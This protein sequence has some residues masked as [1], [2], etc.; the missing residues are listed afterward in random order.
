[1]ELAD[2]RLVVDVHLMGAAICCKAVWETM[3]EQKSGRIVMTTSSSGLY[4]NFGQANYGAAK[5]SL[6]G[7]MQTLAIEG[8]KYGI[9]VNCLAPTAYTR[10]M[11]GILPQE[12]LDVLD[13]SLV[14]PA[15]LPLVS[16][17]GCVSSPVSVDPLVSVPPVSASLAPLS[18][19]CESVP[20][21][22]PLEMAAYARALGVTAA[23]T[24]NRGEVGALPQDFADM[25]GWKE[26]AEAVAISRRLAEVG[27]A[28]TDSAVA[29][30]KGLPDVAD[31]DA[32]PLGHRLTVG[33]KSG[34]R[35]GIVPLAD[36]KKPAE[37]P[38]LGA[39]ASR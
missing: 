12:Q 28:G 38:G 13:P 21:L 33:F 5:M 20:V 30:A 34:W 6:V 25:L 32:D 27:P 3:R 29:Y 24:T 14:S 35:V 18:V 10:M 22:P 8:A 31:V 11:E 9:K 4:G 2:F 36:G 17:V 7:L 23:V 1:M 19:G 39:P 16:S 37:T 15:L 26:Q